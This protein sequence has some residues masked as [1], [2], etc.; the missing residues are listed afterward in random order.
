MPY[1][2]GMKHLL[3]VL[4]LTTSLAHAADAPACSAK[5][6]TELVRELFW[7]SKLKL[8]PVPTPKNESAYRAYSDFQVNDVVSNGYDSEIKR[9]SCSAT[10]GK[11]QRPMKI[12]YT[13]QITEGNPSRFV[14]RADFSDFSDVLAMALREIIVQGIAS[15]P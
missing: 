15:K 2:D 12:G 1:I 4:L 9:R 11:G 3:T 5:P 13:V 10:M 6:V 8:T 14:V 7:E